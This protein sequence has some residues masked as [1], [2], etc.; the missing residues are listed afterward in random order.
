MKL[1]CIEEHAVDAAIAQAAQP[2]VQLEA[3]YLGLQSSRSAA[4]Q[5]G[6]GDRPSLVELGEAIRLGTDLGEGRI[7]NMDEHGIDMQ[8]VSYSSPAQLVPPEQ[9]VTLARAAN[10]RLADAIRVNPTRLSGFATLPWQDPQAAVDELDRAVVDLGLKGV[11]IAGRPGRTFLDD[12]RYAPVLRKLNDLGVPL[13]LH[14]FYPLPQVQEAYYGGFRPEVSAMFS[15]G[16]W[17]WHNEAGVHVLRLILAGVFDQFPNLQVIS[18]HWGEM[19]PF[20]LQR[21][22]DVMPPGVTGLTA[23]INRR[24]SQPRM[25]H[26]Q[27]HVL[28]ATLRVH[29]KRHRYRPDHLVSRLPLPHPRRRPKVLGEPSSYR[30]RGTQTRAPKR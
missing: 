29:P 3:P 16:G 13:Y 2:V 9:A 12:A 24:V 14:P 17:G 10:D 8:I 6:A 11:L 4:C 21:L 26:P 28:R 22:D 18:G 5:P 23:T 20:Y 7:R 27:R 15:I 30:R 25:G 1:I 19:V